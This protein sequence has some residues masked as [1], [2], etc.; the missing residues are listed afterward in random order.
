MN[1]LKYT[2]SVKYIVSCENV[3]ALLCRPFFDMYMKEHKKMFDELEKLGQ[4]YDVDICRILNSDTF[5]RYTKIDATKICMFTLLAGNGFEE[6]QMSAEYIMSQ[7]DLYPRLLKALIYETMADETRDNKGKLI[8]NPNSNR[9]IVV[10]HKLFTYIDKKTVTTI[11]VTSVS[12]GELKNE[13]DIDIVTE[14]LTAKINKI[15]STVF[16]AKH[17]SADIAYACQDIDS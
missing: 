15:I 1:N 7:P 17:I 4:K 16:D 6:I 5:D 8:D 12:Y 10:E 3:K 13:T 14:I 9:V 2:Q 11:P